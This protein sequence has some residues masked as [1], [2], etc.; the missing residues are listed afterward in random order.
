MRRGQ[1]EDFFIRTAIEWAAIAA[2]MRPTSSE[3]N[4][5][6]HDAA[7]GLWR[8]LAWC[9]LLFT[10]GKHGVLLGVLKTVLRRAVGFEGPSLGEPVAAG[11]EVLGHVRRAVAARYPAVFDRAA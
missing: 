8:E 2:A 7:L 1:A 10:A 4:D 9:H 6:L 3:G 11:A 5:P